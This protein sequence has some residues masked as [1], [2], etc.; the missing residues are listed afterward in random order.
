MSLPALWPA[1]FS[2]SLRITSSLARAAL[3]VEN[4]SCALSR[5]ANDR[6][7]SRL[8]PTAAGFLRLV[9]SLSDCRAS[10]CSGSTMAPCWMAWSIICRLEFHRSTNVL[11][12]I[13]S[14]RPCPPGKNRRASS[15]APGAP[16]AC[17]PTKATACFRWPV[18]RCA[19]SR[20]RTSAPSLQN[21]AKIKDA[22][23]PT[24]P[25]P[26]SASSRK[27]KATLAVLG[28]PSST[29]HKLNCSRSTVR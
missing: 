2:W 25:P 3:R 7:G 12:S 11:Q 23:W 21:M 20:S 5:L 17:S 24:S 26:N 15:A 27:T 29:R 1:Y 6:A 16:A 10:A 28:S 13:V 9:A 22:L 4:R 8:R 19:P 14:A 18:S